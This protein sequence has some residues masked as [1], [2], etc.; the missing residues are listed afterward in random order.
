MEARLIKRVSE[1]LPAIMNK[2]VK[3][4]L[5]RRHHQL[6]NEVLKILVRGETITEED[7]WDIL[8][9]NVPFHGAPADEMKLIIDVRTREVEH[10]PDAE[11]EKIKQIFRKKG[12]PINLL[13]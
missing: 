6:L 2:K 8:W 13:R 7:W 5:E 9:K 10:V 11:K 12:L 4:L 3:I 1:K